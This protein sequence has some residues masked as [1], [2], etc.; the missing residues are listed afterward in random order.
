M[1]NGNTRIALVGAGGMSFGPVMSYD[2]ITSEKL[3]GS[4]LVLVD[5]SEDRL[6]QAYAVANRLN[7]AMGSPV[8]IEKEQD[9]VRGV[10]GADFVIVS[11]E[12]DRWK[13]WKEDFE[14]PVK[15]GA[16]QVMGEN[17]G[18]GGLFHSLR[19][20]KLLLEI[21]KQVEENS[22]D[23]M[24]INLTNPMSR[25]TLGLNRGT[26]LKNVGMCHEF[27]GGLLRMSAMLLLPKEKIAAKASGMNH[28]T[29]FY[30]VKH[31]ETG[32][33]LY[34]KLHN[35]IKFFPFLHTKLIRR[36]H[37]EF[38]LFPTSTDSHIGEYLPFVSEEVHPLINFN[39][40]FRNEWKVRNFFCEQYGKGRFWLPVKMLPKSGEEV[41]TIVENIATKDDVY[42]NAVNVPNKGYI[43]N[44]PEGVIVE[45]PAVC[46]GGQLVPQ[47]VPPVHEPLAEIMRL[48]YRLQDMIVDSVLKKD[49]ELAFEALVEDPLSPPSREDC[50]KLFDEMLGLQRDLLPF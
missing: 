9:T 27:F 21:G 29:W 34:P 11:T 46:T 47:A 43:P 45:V 3:A 50:R 12:I 36:C 2:V 4:T 31:A 18:P 23:A 10:T 8:R 40:F 37:N 26:K 48:Q 5:I 17:G 13:H 22:P 25:V 49:P 38:G 6:E 16:T 24:L 1:G 41:I 32:E 33:D 44:L 35:H 15:Y 14:I 42:I 39:D 30:E 7:E 28:F 20:V 19:T